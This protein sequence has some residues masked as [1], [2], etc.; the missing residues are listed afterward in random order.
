MEDFKPRGRASLGVELLN[1]APRD[2][3]LDLGC[4]EG[5][6]ERYLLHG[7]SRR[8][9]GVDSDPVAVDR[10]RRLDPQGEYYD[11]PAETLPFPDSTF[12]KILCL[13]V[14]EHVQDEHRV[15]HEIIRVLAPG[16]RLVISTPHDF[17]TFLDPE[18][19]T[20]RL[21]NLA[22]RVARKQPIPFP[23]HRHYRTGQLRSFFSNLTLEHTHI[24]STPYAMLVA[25]LYGHVPLPLGLRSVCRKITGPLEDLDYRIRL[26]F[27]GGM[28]LM[29]AMT[30]SEG[31]E[32][33]ENPPLPE[34]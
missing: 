34:L 10:A 22:R 28:A 18:N 19:V 1:L 20:P 7:R 15:A 25:L 8:V 14:F 29:L 23:V 33:Q 11:C 4:S 24:G 27:R 16:G 21:K 12:T 26:P 32:Q 31:V 9:V 5:Y 17:L 6:V 2:V 13:D 3:V 30:R